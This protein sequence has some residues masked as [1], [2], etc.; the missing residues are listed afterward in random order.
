MA[1]GDT[2]SLSDREAVL[3]CEVEAAALRAGREVA[4]IERAI[5]AIEEDAAQA[6]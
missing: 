2:R 4:A 6:A 1:D 3:L 5:E